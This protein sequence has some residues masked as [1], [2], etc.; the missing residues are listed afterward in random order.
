MKIL[1]ALVDY[2][3]CAG[4]S[5][6]ELEQILKR[7]P[8]EWP[9]ILRRNIKERNRE[10]FLHLTRKII[11]YARQGIQC[12]VIFAIGS[13]RQSF[14]LDHLNAVNNG[15]G[16]CKNLLPGLVDGLR[17]YLKVYNI[18]HTRVDHTPFLMA[19][20]YS[21]NI[22]GSSLSLIHRAHREYIQPHNHAEWMIFDHEKITLMLTFLQHIVHC[23]GYLRPDVE[24]IMVDD[25]MDILET[26]QSVFSRF[27]CLIPHN[28]HITLVNYVEGRLIDQ[29]TLNTSALRGTGIE[30]SE[31]NLRTLLTIINLFHLPQTSNL[32]LREISWKNL[33]R[34]P[35]PDDLRPLF[36]QPES[37]PCVT[38]TAQFF[39]RP[40][41][42]NETSVKFD[43][44]C[45]LG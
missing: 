7:D 11:D 2:D 35:T 21:G 44:S 12:K 40:A 31:F 15:N 17:D 38:P 3:G 23:E 5:E 22:S 37:R 45:T 20:I 33:P 13:A 18:P 6:P 8:R 34:I 42:Q 39:G 43:W 19:D 9:E 30:W 27:P 24:C 36:H 10:L 41:Q 32:Q 1:L 14:A 16:S 4:F 26:I 28:T 25:R 29:P